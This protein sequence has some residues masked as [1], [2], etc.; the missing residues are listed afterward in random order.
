MIFHSE[1]AV[2]AESTEVGL[3]L[4]ERREGV[5]RK[6]RIGG[7]RRPPTK[8]QAVEDVRS[9]SDRSSGRVRACIKT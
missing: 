6:V 8:R 3:L 5:V 2:L 7:N 9:G 4:G 1:S